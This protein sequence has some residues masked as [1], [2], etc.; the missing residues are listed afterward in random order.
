VRNG[1]EC[2]HRLIRRATSRHLRGALLAWITLGVAAIVIFGTAERWGGFVPG[3]LFFYTASKGFFY[4]LI[5]PVAT[6]D[7]VPLTRLEYLGAGLYSALA[8]VFLWRFIP[9]RKVRATI[10]DRVALTVFAL[11]KLD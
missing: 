7:P 1:D 10:L 6:H 9:P 4:A 3:F 11:C 2:L 5:P 8:I